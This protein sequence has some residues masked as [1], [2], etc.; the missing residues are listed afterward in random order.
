LGID[1][2]VRDAGVEVTEGGQDQGMDLTYG[3]DVG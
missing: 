3:H 1:A 2:A